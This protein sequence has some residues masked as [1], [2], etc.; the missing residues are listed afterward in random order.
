M[1]VSLKQPEIIAALTLYLAHQGINVQGK[2]VT[3]D[4][5]AGRKESGLSAEV[6]IGEAAPAVKTAPV[7]RTVGGTAS[8]VPP[9]PEANEAQA[10]AQEPATATTGEVVAGTATGTTGSS[11]FS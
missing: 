10:A 7:M 8:T 5:T 1:K 2:D 9:L 4:F 11:L 3:V 6:N